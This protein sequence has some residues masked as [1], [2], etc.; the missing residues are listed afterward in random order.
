MRRGRYR[1]YRKSAVARERR[2]SSALPAALVENA[3]FGLMPCAPSGWRIHQRFESQDTRLLEAYRHVDRVK[4]RARLTV[5]LEGGASGDRLA[6]VRRRGSQI[7]R[8]ASVLRAYGIKTW[9]RKR[10]IEGGRASGQIC[11]SNPTSVRI[12]VDRS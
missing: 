12:K 2:D 5:N 3:V 4:K 7:F 6:H 9:K 8:I 11:S 1:V 10:R